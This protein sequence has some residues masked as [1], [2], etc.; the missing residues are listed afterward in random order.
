MRTGRTGS[1]GEASVV[2]PAQREGRPGAHGDRE[3][4]HWLFAEGAGLGREGQLAPR[5]GDEL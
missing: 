3:L 2:A 5:G 4:G 1:R